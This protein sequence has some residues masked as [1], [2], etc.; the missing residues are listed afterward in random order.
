MYNGNLRFWDYINPLNWSIGWYPM[1]MQEV[2]T[3]RQQAEQLYNDDGSDWLQM[4]V[5][6][7]TFWLGGIMCSLLVWTMSRSLMATGQRVMEGH[8]HPLPV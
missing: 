3:L 8:G 1:W 7:F 5:S 2:F 6:M 4:M